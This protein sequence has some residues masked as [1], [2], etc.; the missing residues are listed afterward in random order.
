[1]IIMR[2]EIHHLTPHDNMIVFSCLYFCEA[3][4]IDY[5]VQVGN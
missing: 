3:N 1:M 5:L 2:L 4:N